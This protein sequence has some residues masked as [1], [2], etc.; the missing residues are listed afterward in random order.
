MRR[1][2]HRTK[3]SSA[4]QTVVCQNCGAE[5]PVS[6]SVCPYCRSIYLPAAETDYMEKLEDLRDDLEHL[7]HQP[8]ADARTHFRS[9]RKWFL[10]FLI[11]LVSAVLGITVYNH[12]Q[13][14]QE[15]ERQKEE[16]LWQREGFAR[17]EEL[18]QAG[19]YATLI[20]EYSD[21]YQAGHQVYQ[22][23][24]SI[25]CDWYSELENTK[26]CL[27]TYRNG[28]GSLLSLF[29]DELEL[30]LIDDLWQLTDEERGVLLSLRE[31]ILEDFYTRFP[32]PEED[33][34]EFRKQ[35]K[36]DGF[37]SFTACE[38]YLKEKG[39]LP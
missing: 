16:Y 32:L 31:P 11:L 17:F 34:A 24:H 38:K 30:F 3:Q 2:S 37:L 15:A 35:M 26:I 23:K 6:V 10:P 5:F 8:A 29:Y 18:Y 21:A 7:G 19:D 25:F 39:Y 33:L 9:L 22:F 28:A 4:D 1:L 27:E 14:R 12:V 20:R 36:L 13:S